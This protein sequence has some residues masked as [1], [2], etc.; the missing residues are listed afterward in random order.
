MGADS[1]ASDGEDM[2]SLTNKK[3]F[4]V[5]PFLMGCVGSIRMTQ[6][7][8]YRLPA[9]QLG[10]GT[11]LSKYMA[12]T[13]VDSIQRVF[14]DNG[15][16]MLHDDHSAEGITLVGFQGHL[17]RL[18]GDLQMVERAEGFE[19]IGCGSPY[20]LGSLFETTQDQPFERVRSALE[21]SHHFS[22]HVRPPY[23]IFSEDD[24]GK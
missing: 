12:T 13:F 5:G 17:F 9:P 11:D 1:A 7:I 18:E 21:A 14:R 10:V 4:F 23:T 15:F 6:L 2:V 8:Q 22:A 3:I 24:I 20:A 19:A 16:S